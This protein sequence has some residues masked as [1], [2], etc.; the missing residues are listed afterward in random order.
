MSNLGFS[1]KPEKGVR[2]PY[3]EIIASF[4]MTDVPILSVDIPSGWDVITGPPAEG[5]GSKVYPQALISL[6]APKICAGRYKGRHFVGG[7]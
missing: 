3:K 1:F 2:D 5:L 4:E 7:R 6:T